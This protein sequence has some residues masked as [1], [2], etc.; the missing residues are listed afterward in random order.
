MKKTLLL[1]SFLASITLRCATSPIAG[2]SDDV[3]TGT[4][5]GK[6]TCEKD[7][8]SGEIIV[9][10]YKN[11]SL[12]TAL[13]KAAQRAIAPLKSLTTKNLEF[14]FDSLDS[15][16]YSI[17]SLLEG[18]IIGDTENIHVTLREHKTVRLVVLTVMKQTFVTDIDNSQH[19]TL[20]AFTI[21]NT[22][23]VPDSASRYQASFVGRDTLSM[24]IDYLK[25][26]ASQ[27]LRAR[28]VRNPD[29]SYRIV[30]V[31][32]INPII[33]AAVPATS[34]AFTG[35]L[36]TGFAVRQNG[37]AALNA[38]VTLLQMLV[39]EVS[40]S[41]AVLAN[42]MKP[43]DSTTIN[44]SG[45]FSFSVADSGAYV[46]E[47]LDH[48]SAG[49]LFQAQI[50]RKNPVFLVPTTLL[51]ELGTIKG[52]I[53]YSLL[54]GDSAIVFVPELS[55]RC[56]ADDKGV[57]ICNRVFPG[58]YSLHMICNGRLAASPLDTIHLKVMPGDTATPLGFALNNAPKF[59]STAEQMARSIVS[60]AIYCDT[61]HSYDPDRDTL[62]FVFIHHPP[63]MMLSDSIVYWAPSAKDTG[64]FFISVFVMDG[65]GAKDTIDWPVFVTSGK[66]SGNRPPVFVSQPGQ[67][68]DTISVGETYS[69]RYIATDPDGDHVNFLFLKN[70]RGLT[71]NDSLLHW[72]PDSNDVGNHELMLL[73][74]DDKGGSDTL[75]WWITVKAGPY[76]NNPPLFNTRPSDMP[77][78]IAVGN[79]YKARVHAYD[80]DG[81]TL[82]YGFIAGPPGSALTDSLFTWTPDS[83][84]TG[85]ATVAIYVTDGK[86]GE[87]TLQWTIRV[88]PGDSRPSTTINV[89]YDSL[90]YGEIYPSSKV[91][92]YQFRG[93]TGDKISLRTRCSNNL[94]AEITVSDPSNSM[95]KT[96]TSGFPGQ[97]VLMDTFLLTTT[98]TYSIK[99]NSLG[100]YYSG[101]YAFILYSRQKQLSE[102][103]MVNYEQIYTDSIIDP[104]QIKTYKFRGFDMDKI[105]FRAFCLDPLRGMVGITSAGNMPLVMKGSDPSGSLLVDTQNIWWADT[106]FIQIASDSGF[107][108][109]SY[110]F[111]LY[112]LQRQKET[113]RSLPF[114]QIVTDTLQ[115]R[116]MMKTYRFQGTSGDTISL[117]TVC[118][119]TLSATV[120]VFNDSNSVLAT[121]SSAGSSGGET[122]LIDH[123][124]LAKTG[125]YAI[126]L[127]SIEAL[128]G[129]EFSLWLTKN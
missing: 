53:P 83:A 71:F 29:G 88:L 103:A 57:F 110:S 8:L 69:R 126:Q 95:V 4:I 47:I 42:T 25:N 46:V 125:T 45:S 117:R 65:S 115:N 84:D 76:H 93:T 28:L 63:G 92:R 18:H 55:V 5:Y 62:R 50:T 22:I 112:S 121:R 75:T 119:A 111:M 41:K 34:A 15:G 87:D 99:I 33:I 44:S 120:A 39:P 14:S 26:G 19:I 20:T 61:L 96:K 128:S 40:S 109:G 70:D 118:G 67:M 36:I 58:T 80:Q 59:I 66:S 81:D 90:T 124:Y 116:L 17:R 68:T 98:G 10:L 107:S 94:I 51:A 9:E 114:N 97:T 16:D 27:T 113:S 13:K 100:G 30:L 86:G 7:T 106:Y 48:D 38:K 31:D 82:W 78:S 23:V 77:P 74:L 35:G 85:Y 105:N 91:D 73:A 43:Y 21:N 3:N 60:G 89:G 64:V 122:L 123:L 6:V 54:C 2:T 72:V 11:D 108:K 56:K 52:K 79:V 127:K 101:E 129:G 104:V 32:A 1:I 37:S 102:S 49:A 24:A 12:K